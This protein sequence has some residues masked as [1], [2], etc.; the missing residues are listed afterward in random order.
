[1]HILGDIEAGVVVGTLAVSHFFAVYPEIHGAVYA[2]EV[3]EDLLV[4][5]VGG[6][7]EVAA[8]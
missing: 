6:N 7:S 5:P 1:M 3:Y 8:V 2:V 4:F